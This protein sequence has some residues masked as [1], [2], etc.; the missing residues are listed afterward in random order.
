MEKD[1]ALGRMLHDDSTLIPHGV[2]GQVTAVVG[3]DDPAPSAKVTP[4]VTEGT[5]GKA[6]VPPSEEIQPSEEP[7]E[8]AP[9]KRELR[10]PL[11][12]PVPL[13]TLR[14]RIPFLLDHGLNVE[15][16]L[17]DTTYNGEIT[18]RELERL[19]IELRRNK[20]KVIAHLPH[21]DLK[22][23]S[24]DKMILQHSMDAVQEGLEIG[25]ILGARIAIFQSGFSNHVKP[26]DIDWW[27]AECIVALEDLVSRAKEEE[28]IVA[29]ENTWESDEAVIGRLYDAVDS[30][31]FRF[32]CDVG[33]AACFSQFAPEDWIVQFRDRIASFGF[34]DNDGMADQH[35]AC[36]EGVVGFD[37][38]SETIHEELTEPVNITLDVREE[39]LLP[40]IRHLEECG[41]HFERAHA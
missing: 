26:K 39:D 41:F 24:H 31:W 35:M 27:V 23:A 25:K 16:D 34:H 19:A 36:G 6:A 12:Y 8:A 38:I 3:G 17:S 33:H 37:V 1:Q 22:L 32:C 13:A 40:S 20:I 5:E 18:I 21:H 2:E 7:E 14:E 29:L 30:P 11:S 28:V 15:V 4:Q 9:E 10:F